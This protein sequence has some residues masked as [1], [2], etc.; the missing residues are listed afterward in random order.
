VIHVQMNLGILNRKIRLLN[1]H[2]ERARKKK[3]LKSNSVV[4]SDSKLARLM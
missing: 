1:C 2:Q 3:K 4:L